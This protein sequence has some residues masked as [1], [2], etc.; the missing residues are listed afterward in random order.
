MSKNSKF[1]LSAVA[2]GIS[3]NL[4]TLHAQEQNQN[5]ADGDVELIQVRKKM[6]WTLRELDLGHW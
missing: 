2:V 3:L 1:L 5:N 4:G 6:F